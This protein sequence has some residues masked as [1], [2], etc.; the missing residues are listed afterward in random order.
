MA[1]E[2]LAHVCVFSVP[3]VPVPKPRM[4]RRD[5]WAKRGCVVRY[6]DFCDRVRAAAKLQCLKGETAK[7]DGLDMEFH[8]PMPA[9]WSKKRKRAFDGQ[10]HRQVPDVDNLAKG[11]SDALLEDDSSI[12]IMRCTKHWCQA[13]KARAVV[14]LIFSDD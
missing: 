9:S 14:T 4:T 6:R 11:V 13:E 8:M 2:M 1:P 7:L 10:P 5:Q 12:W 3:G